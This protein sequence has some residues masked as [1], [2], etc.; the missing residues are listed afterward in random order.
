MSK[1]NTSQQSSVVLIQDLSLRKTNALR[2]KVYQGTQK[3]LTTSTVRLLTPREGPHVSNEMW[4][5]TK[6]QFWLGVR[7][8]KTEY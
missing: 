1:A 5:G 3:D 6:T 4:K 8:T 7:I 2:G